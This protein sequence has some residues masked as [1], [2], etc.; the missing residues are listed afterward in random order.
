M[1]QDLSLRELLEMLGEN[2]R[3]TVAR[4][5]EIL[6]MPRAE[7]KRC[8]SVFIH[9]SLAKGVRAGK[10]VDALLKIDAHLNAYGAPTPF[11]TALAPLTAELLVHVKETLLSDELEKRQADTAPIVFP[12]KRTIIAAPPMSVSSENFQR[13]VDRLL[14]AVQRAAVRKCRLVVARDTEIDP[15]VEERLNLLID[16]LRAQRVQV[17]VHD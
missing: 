7:Q 15:E 8:L 12:R 5:S 9:Q 4:L 13:F 17:E 10:I 11:A 16:D 1:S 14:G 3:P 2:R 6:Q